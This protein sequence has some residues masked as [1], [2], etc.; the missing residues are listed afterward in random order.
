MTRPYSE[1]CNIQFGPCK[2]LELELGKIGVL[3]HFQIHHCISSCADLYLR[4]LAFFPA[5]LLYLPDSLF[6]FSIS[7][8][9]S[10]LRPSYPLV[11]LSRICSAVRCLSILSLIRRLPSRQFHDARPLLIRNRPMRFVRADRL[12]TAVRGI[13]SWKSLTEMRE[14]IRWMFSIHPPLIADDI[15]RGR[16][17]QSVIGLSMFSGL[18]KAGK[19][20]LVTYWWSLLL[21]MTKPP[22]RSGPGS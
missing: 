12:V 1:R 7:A 21:R 5:R 15:V 8:I 14:S 3:V 6:S 19:D 9:S 10:L 17:L 20:L 16:C 18:P 13:R 2:L 4:L 22:K 11:V